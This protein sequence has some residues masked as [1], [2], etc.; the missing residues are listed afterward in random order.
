MRHEEDFPGNMHDD[1]ERES[2]EHR[3]RAFT[4][5]AKRP[6]H[7]RA[8][9]G[10]RWFRVLCAVPPRL[11][12]ILLCMMYDIDMFYF[13]KYR[14]KNRA[15]KTGIRKPKTALSKDPIAGGA[16]TT[17]HHRSQ[18]NIEYAV[19]CSF[20]LSLVASCSLL[21]ASFEVDRGSFKMDIFAY[22]CPKIRRPATRP[23]DDPKP[24]VRA[25]PS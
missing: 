15:G 1:Q 7:R 2:T 20:Y 16:A 23:F 10:G 19:V 12:A 14:R 21:V 9:R 11:S 13:Q 8:A 24:K 22:T 18:A 5:A 4:P 6:D 3:D 17:V 25:T